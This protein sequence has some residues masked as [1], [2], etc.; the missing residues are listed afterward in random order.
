MPRHREFAMSV[1]KSAL[2]VSVLLT[3]AGLA[4]C[5]TT[6]EQVYYAGTPRVSTTVI[7]DDGPRW[8]P[9]PVV[10][11]EPPIRRVRP[12]YRGGPEPA[13]YP[14]P[15]LRR[16]QPRERGGPE[17]APYPPPHLQRPAPRYQ[18]GPEPMPYPPR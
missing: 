13:P 7:Y 18:G 12:I 1:L 15:H 14:P 8:R 3:T 9:P 10:Y 17:P 2:V 16:M 4:G 11:V 6:E 5:Q